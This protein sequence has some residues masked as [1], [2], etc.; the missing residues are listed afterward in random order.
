M[1]VLDPFMAP[2][3]K[4]RVPSDVPFPSSA[5]TM[6]FQGT[7]TPNTSG[8]FALLFK[9]Q[10]GVPGAWNEYIT[11]LADNTYTAANGFLQV[12]G[13]PSGGVRTDYIPAAAIT[14]VRVVGAGIKCWYIG[15]ESDRSGYYVSAFLPRGTTRDGVVIRQG[16]SEDQLKET[17]YRTT[18]GNKATPECIWVPRDDTDFDYMGAL[19][20]RETS[21]CV[22][23]GFGLPNANCIKWEIIVHAEYIP[24][25]TVAGYRMLSTDVSLASRTDA[26]MILGQITNKNPSYVAS[27]ESGYSLFGDISAISGETAY[28][29]WYDKTVDYISKNLTV[30]DAIDLGASAINMFL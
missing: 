29:S 19:D 6:T 20:I 13:G 1:A 12:G 14:K 3:N 11:T 27:P 26:S 2:Q 30:G 22:I 8:N 18:C 17:P 9:P 4:A 25:P 10:C 23:A 21:V 7:V 24:D 28:H 15:K 16:Y 5:I